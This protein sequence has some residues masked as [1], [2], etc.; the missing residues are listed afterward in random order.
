MPSKVPLIR[1]L[2]KVSSQYIILRSEVALSSALHS[3]FPYTGTV[4][5]S[6]AQL[7]CNV[8]FVQ[9]ELDFH[10]IFRFYDMIR[11]LVYIFSRSVIEKGRILFRWINKQ[12]Q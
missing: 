2:L 10:L 3:I 6:H 8:L 7:L 9:L 11:L 5:N 12:I 1:I 4:T